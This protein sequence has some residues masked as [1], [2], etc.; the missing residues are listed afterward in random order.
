MSKTFNLEIITPERIVYS[1]AVQAIYLR[2]QEGHL[3]ILADHA[4]LVTFVPSCAVKI[5]LP[6]TEQFAALG[7]GF[8][9]V[10]HN[11]VT[12][13]VKVA[14]LASEIDAESAELALQRAQQHV[15]LGITVC[16]YMKRA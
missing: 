11:Q 8:L 12:L 14:E 9:E 10:N 13:L 2:G 16:N 4:P 15:A 6:E 5:V 1:G 3:G 7:Q